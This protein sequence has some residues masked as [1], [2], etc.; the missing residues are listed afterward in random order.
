MKYPLIVVKFRVSKNLSLRDQFFEIAKRLLEDD[1]SEID[2][3]I[4]VANLFQSFCL[5]I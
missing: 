4:K 3:N 1:V 2:Q 5:S